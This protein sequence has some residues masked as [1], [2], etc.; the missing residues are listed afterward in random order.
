MTMHTE[1]WFPTVIW[2]AMIHK[3]DNDEV[4]RWAYEKQK[5]DQGRII[6]NYGDWQSN[7][8]QLG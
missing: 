6:S 4:K 8:I 5:Q 7:D 1:L 2:S 3:V